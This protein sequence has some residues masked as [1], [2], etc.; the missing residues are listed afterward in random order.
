MGLWS[1]RSS[2]PRRVLQPKYSSAR[3]VIERAF[4]LLNVRWGI[5]RSHSFYPINVTACCLLHNFICN[6]MPDD[7]FK[8]DIA[9]MGDHVIEAN[10]DCIAIIDNHPVW[11]ARRDSLVESMYND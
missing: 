10:S 4:G 8:R 2:E 7:P 9:N 11:N 6:E 1:R 3:N 5:L